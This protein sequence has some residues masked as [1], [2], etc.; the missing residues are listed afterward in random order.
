MRRDGRYPSCVDSKSFEALMSKEVVFR[1]FGEL[2]MVTVLVTVSVPVSSH[3]G[4]RMEAR[5]ENRILPE[6]GGRGYNNQS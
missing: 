2:K 5:S 4:R 6:S 3:P 1:F